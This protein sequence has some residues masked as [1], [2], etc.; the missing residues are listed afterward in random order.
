MR[1]FKRQL[2]ATPHQPSFR[3][4]PLFLLLWVVIM[5]V[6]AWKLIQ[7]ARD[8]WSNASRTQLIQEKLT[9]EEQKNLELMKRLEEADTPFAKEKMIRDELNMQRPGDTTLHIEK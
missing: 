7:S 9:K 4:H 2:K 6:V 1:T 3:E 8:I 5:S